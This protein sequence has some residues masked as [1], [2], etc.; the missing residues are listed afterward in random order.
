M[1][2]DNRLKVCCK[3]CMTCMLKSSYKRHH[4]SK[5]HQTNLKK[6]QQEKSVTTAE[7]QNQTLTKNT[8]KR[9]EE[10][11]V[12]G[13]ETISEKVTKLIHSS[14]YVVFTK[15]YCP[16]C[17]ALVKDW[18][19]SGQSFVNYVIDEEGD[20]GSQIHEYLKTTYK[21][22]TVPL[23]FHRGTFIGGY[24]AWKQKQKLS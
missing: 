13:S 15:S 20:T 7:K 6:L 23:I 3:I 9:T 22:R 14:E 1:V 18:Q 24:D 19:D 11:P 10:K 8:T 12:S 17:K 16:Y 5:T 2:T 21:H 4:Q